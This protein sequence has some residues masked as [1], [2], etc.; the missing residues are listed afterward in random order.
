MLNQPKDIRTKFMHKYI[1]LEIKAENRGLINSLDKKVKILGIVEGGCPD[2][3]N[4]LPMLEKLIS[5]NPNIELKLLTRDYLN[6]ELQ[7]F[8]IDGKVKLPTFIFMDEE[9]GIKGAFV[10]KPKE[11]VEAELTVL[12]LSAKGV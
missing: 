12:I 11:D 5:T 6:G 2:T 4:F 1:P 7:Q 3:Q 10:E 9:Y 8:E